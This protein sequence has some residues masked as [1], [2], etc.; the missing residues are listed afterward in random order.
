MNNLC[1]LVVCGAPLARRA[2]DFVRHLIDVGWRVQVVTTPAATNWVDET[3]LKEAAGQA[4]RSVHRPVDSPKNR[5]QPGA[6][7]VVPITF[8]TVGKLAAGIADTYAH[9][10][11]CEALGDG[12]P[13]LAVPMVNNRLWGHPAWQRNVHFLT[14]AGVRWVSVHDGTAGPPEVVQSGTG[15]SLVDQFD[16]EWISGHLPLVPHA[17]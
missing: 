5:E 6:V 15:E 2:P 4:P 14:A 13:I 11:L 16:P 7:A 3:A 12:I 17:P 10:A 1:T 8:N 9:S